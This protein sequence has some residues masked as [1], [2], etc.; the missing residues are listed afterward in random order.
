MKNYVIFAIQKKECEYY[1]MEQFQA[2]PGKFLFDE[3]IL[4]YFV[5]QAAFFRNALKSLLKFINI[6]LPNR[7]ITNISKIF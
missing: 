2:I 5:W 6:T 1:L 4:F 3:P 7:Q